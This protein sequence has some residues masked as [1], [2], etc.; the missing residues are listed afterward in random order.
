MIQQMLAIWSLVPLPFLKLAWISGSSL[1]T[2]CWGLAWRNFTSMWD[3]CNCAVVWT[4]FGIA[5]LWNWNENWPFPV[6]SAVFNSLWPHGLYSPWNSPGQNTRVGSLSLLQGI[7]PTQGSNPGL[8]HCWRIIYQ[9]S[10]KGSLRILEWAIYPFSNPG[11]ELGSPAL[12]A[13]SWFPELSGKPRVPLKPSLRV[14][15]T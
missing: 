7:F 5:F 11:I 15:V 2:Y 8:P 10:H 1:F 6:L 9:L 4:F 14:I 13:D 12:Q 3:E